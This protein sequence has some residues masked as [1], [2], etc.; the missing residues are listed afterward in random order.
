MRINLIDFTKL[1]KGELDQLIEKSIQ[2]KNR[3]IDERGK[4]MG[5]YFF[6]YTLE[7]LS[8]TI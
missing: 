3:I 2:E 6:D 8:Q 7:E 1:A 5:E 4:E